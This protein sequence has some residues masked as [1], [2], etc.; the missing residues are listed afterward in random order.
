MTADKM[1]IHQMID[2][3]MTEDKMTEDSMIV[4]RM[5]EDKMPEVNDYEKNHSNIYKI[6]QYNTEQYK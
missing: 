4:D 2:V 6:C 1:N 3:K 5:T